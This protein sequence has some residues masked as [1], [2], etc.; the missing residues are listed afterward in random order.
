M[1]RAAVLWVFCS[2]E[3]WL[4]LLLVVRGAGRAKVL[5]PTEIVHWQLRDGN[6]IDWP[7]YS[8][9]FADRYRW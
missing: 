7:S 6:Q 8:G 4:V 2:V 9:W 1:P 5:R 3:V